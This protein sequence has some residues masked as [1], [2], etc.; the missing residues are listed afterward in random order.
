MNNG[1]LHAARNTLL[2]GGGR[3]HFSFLCFDFLQTSCFQKP[4]SV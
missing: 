4:K 1:S 2:V 3:M